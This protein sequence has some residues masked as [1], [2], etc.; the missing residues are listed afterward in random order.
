MTVQGPVGLHQ[1][2]HALCP[3]PF[4]P[5]FG[6]GA[7]PHHRRL[8][9][10]FCWFA[11]PW[12]MAHLLSNAIR[13]VRSFSDLD[14]AAASPTRSPSLHRSNSTDSS[15]VGTP[16]PATPSPTRRRASS[17][18]ASTVQSPTREA[19]RFG[20]SP[21]P[22]QSPSQRSRVMD[23]VRGALRG[24]S[25]APEAPAGDAAPEP[26]SEPDPSEFPFDEAVYIKF[27]PIQC[28][29][30][31]GSRMLFLGVRAHFAAQFDPGTGALQAVHDLDGVKVTA[32]EGREGREFVVSG[33][34]LAATWRLRAGSP[35]AA[36][37]W[38][39]AFRYAGRYAHALRNHREQRGR[40]EEAD[41]KAQEKLREAYIALIERA[42]ASAPQSMS[43]TGLRGA[44]GRWAP[45]C[46]GC[47]KRY[48][49]ATHVPLVLQCAHTACEVCVTTL[50]AG[51]AGVACPQCAC[52]TPAADVATLPRNYAILDLKL[53]VSEAEF[54]R[55]ELA[56][57]VDAA[58]G[59]CPVC[60]DGYNGKSPL[61]LVCGHTIC[62][63]CALAVALSGGD[64][65]VACPE[66]RVPTSLET[67]L[68][69]N[70]SLRDAVR[71]FAG[72]KRRRGAAARRWRVLRHVVWAAAALN[73]AIAPRHP[74]LAVRERARRNAR[75]PTLSA[76]AKTPPAH[77]DPGANPPASPPPATNASSARRRSAPMAHAAHASV[78]RLPQ[79]AP[80]AAS[81]IP[82]PAAAAKPAGPAT[83]PRKV[84]CSVGP[85]AAA[86]APAP[87]RPGSAQQRSSS[88]G[89]R[90]PFVSAPPSSA[91][92]SREA[93]SGSPIQASS[94]PSPT[95]TVPPPG[96]AARV[97]QRATTPPPRIPVRTA[98]RV[99]AP[100]HPSV[101]SHGHRCNSMEDLR[102]STTV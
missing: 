2:S 26:A 69:L 31:L 92:P 4:A 85:A 60:L 39:Q 52:T 7:S 98:L 58:G 47:Q 93:A 24:S 14:S 53:H 42:V 81:A 73:T 20:S 32:T 48:D 5:P 34:H 27:G 99:A 9:Q 29:R 13:R 46:P 88:T 95:S 44:R 82:A 23:V 72:I 101:C 76:P 80:T 83:A 19:R 64:G 45:A 16:G 63:K 97:G 40:R 59:T 50:K 30:R 78:G 77:R 22:N 90:T 66:C 62:S 79:A 71:A 86:S 21:S 12:P 49:G 61:V 3:P 33:P 1:T 25:P 28:T 6:I 68:R 18:N 57:L 41:P 56:V 11:G 51:H 15:P 54:R 70:A 84:P 17:N 100:L 8:A 75:S 87:R 37:E 89:T 38:R 10:Q 91:F 36:A 65:T 67:E 102:V 55:Q 35:A 96:G 94:Y 74:H 43:R